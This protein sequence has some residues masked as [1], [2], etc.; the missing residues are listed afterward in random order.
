MELFSELRTLKQ[1]LAFIGPDDLV[2]VI[3][4]AGAGVGEAE[5]GFLQRERKI[6]QIVQV[7]GEPPIPLRK[8]RPVADWAQLLPFLRELQAGDE[9]FLP[10][11]TI[12]LADEDTKLLNKYRLN[13]HCATKFGCRRQAKRDF[14]VL[15][16]H[17]FPGSGAEISR[18]EEEYDLSVEGEARARM[19]LGWA[20]REG[21]FWKMVDQVARNT[22]DPKRMAYVRLALRDLHEA[23]TL[24]WRRTPYSKKEVYIVVDITEEERRK[25]AKAEGRFLLFTSFVKG[26]TAASEKEANAQKKLRPHAFIFTV[27]PNSRPIEPALDFG[28]ALAPPDPTVPTSSLSRRPNVLVNIYNVFQVR[29]MAA[30]NRNGEL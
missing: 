24:E 8:V 29:A 7:G 30:N 22:T 2:K 12:L 26:Y 11:S 13:F 9:L 17:L 14:L 5:M 21:F 23:V 1:E 18:F 27:M 6:Y 15:A 19:A 20:F 28:F 3:V 25:L 10:S 16:R 4:A